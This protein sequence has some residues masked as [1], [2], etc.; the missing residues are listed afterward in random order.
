MR[1][2]KH[3][4]ECMCRSRAGLREVAAEQGSSPTS[5]SRRAGRGCQSRRRGARLSM[6]SF[7]VTALCSVGAFAQEA[8]YTA[9]ATMPS[10][11][12][13]VFREQFN[14]SRFGYNPNT[15]SDHTDQ[16]EFRSSIAYGLDRGLALNLDIPIM[17]R[18]TVTGRD[19]DWDRG[20]GNLDLTLK[21]RIYKDDTGG[22]D[23]LRI[24]LLAGITFA[25]GD[26]SDFSS[27][28]VNPH[29]G[30]VATKVLGRHGFNQEFH[31][32]FNTGGDVADNF[33]GE[34][35]DDAFEYNSAY[36]YRIAPPA[37]TSETKGAWYV[38]AELNGLYETGGDNDLRFSPGLMYEGRRFAFEIMAQVPVYQDVNERPELKFG[39]GIG[40]RLTF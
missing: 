4:M 18:D 29:L 40:V 10:P 36:L 12:V 2:G 6:A 32:T 30:I 3:L 20:V 14:Y 21:Y 37:Y 5:S 1:A 34:G 38:T 7:L 33:G 15:G 35:P 13:T 31:Y 26:D 17:L 22:I 25:S 11:G 9:A 16:Y 24:A 23:T 39:V 28:S 27:Q 19:N 8:M